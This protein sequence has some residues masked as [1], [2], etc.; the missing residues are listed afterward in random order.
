MR[1]TDISFS[2]LVLFILLVL[3]LLLFF[4]TCAN[5]VGSIDRSSR[6]SLGILLGLVAFFTLSVI[7]FLVSKTNSKIAD[8]SNF[9][10]SRK[11]LERIRNENS[12]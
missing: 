10:L 8:A 3:D 2:L 5:K 1:V 9:T 12:G 6:L 7:L 11:T 4:L